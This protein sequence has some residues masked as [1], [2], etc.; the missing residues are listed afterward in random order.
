MNLLLRLAPLVLVPRRPIIPFVL[1]PPRVP[2]IMISHGSQNWSSW[3]WG[4]SSPQRTADHQT[5]GP[6]DRQ[7]AGPRDEEPGEPLITEVSLAQSEFGFSSDWSREPCC[8]CHCRYRWKLGFG[9]SGGAEG[10]AAD[11]LC[12][13]WIAAR[14]CGWYA[15]LFSGVRPSKLN[16]LICSTWSSVCISILLHKQRAFPALRLSCCSDEVPNLLLVVG[17]FISRKACVVSK[18]N[19]ASRCAVSAPQQTDSG[20]HKKVYVGCSNGRDQMSCF[21]RHVYAELCSFNVAVFFWS[22]WNGHW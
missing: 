5:P 13:S 7:T 19:F 17:T 4:R 11:T 12:R 1:I 22:S 9:V 6:P 2:E 18:A 10:S 8:C 20:S 15:F 14:N 3:Y 21:Y 16:T